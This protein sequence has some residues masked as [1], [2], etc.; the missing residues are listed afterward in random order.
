MRLCEHDDCVR[1]VVNNME[2]SDVSGYEK[3]QTT[4]TVRGMH[5]HSEE[6]A[7]RRSVSSVMYARGGKIDL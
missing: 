7:K 4:D 5:R 1:N 6:G 2:D 3:I